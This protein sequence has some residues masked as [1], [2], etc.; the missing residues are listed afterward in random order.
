MGRSYLAVKSK[1]SGYAPNG[2]LIDF[3]D[4]ALLNNFTINLKEYLTKL[5]FIYLRIS[6]NF[7]YKVF[8]KNNIA[9]K[10]YSSILENMEH[11]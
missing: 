10:N 6:P 2:Y 7:A 1:R 3:N 4:Q 5:N 9:V 11:Y 8:D